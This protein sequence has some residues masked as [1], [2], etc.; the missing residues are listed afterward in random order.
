MKIK[1]DKSEVTSVPYTKSTFL[2]QV[3]MTIVAILFL[4]PIF[5]VFNYSFKTKKE[6]YLTNALTLPNSIQFENYKKAFEKLNLNKGIASISI[7]LAKI[8]ITL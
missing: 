3:L 2:V 7:H 8:N 6:L 4:L 5:V 1:K